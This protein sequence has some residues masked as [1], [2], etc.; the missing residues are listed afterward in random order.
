MKADFDALRQENARKLVELEA[1][2]EDRDEHLPEYRDQTFMR[3]EDMGDDDAGRRE[4]SD[5]YTVVGY[6]RELRYLFSMACG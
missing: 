3:H 5:L 1:E 2:L 4:P 6:I